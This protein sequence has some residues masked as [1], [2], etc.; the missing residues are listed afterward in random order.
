MSKKS[1]SSFD[2]AN[3]LSTSFVI[4]STALEL[5]LVNTITLAKGA[6]AIVQSTD[7]ALARYIEMTEQEISKMHRRESVRVD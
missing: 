3:I 4:G 2:P 5:A 1:Q 7:L 6:Q